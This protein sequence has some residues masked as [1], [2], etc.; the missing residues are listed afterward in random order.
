MA[1]I[2]LYIDEDVTDLLARILRSR[3]YD[4]LGT[5]EA[6]K[7][8]NTDREQIA[9]AIQ[10]KRAILT[11]NVQEYTTYATE[12]YENDIHHYGFILSPQLGLKELLSRVLFL[13]ENVTAEE[14]QNRRRWLTPSP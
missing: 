7:G 9:F 3:G 2:R 11:F 10:E 8:G 14:I 5:R 13:L 12:Y 6:G 1:T 4:A